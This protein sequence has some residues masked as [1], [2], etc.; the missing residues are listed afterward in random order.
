MPNRDQYADHNAYLVIDL[1]LF[2]QSTKSAWCNMLLVWRMC[3]IEQVFSVD[4]LGALHNL[5]SVVQDCRLV[6]H[7]SILFCDINFLMIHYDIDKNMLHIPVFAFFFFQPCL[8]GN[9]LH[10]TLTGKQ[11]GHWMLQVIRCLTLISVIACVTC[12]MRSLLL[13]WSSRLHVASGFQGMK[14]NV[15][16]KEGI[17]LRE[18]APPSYDMR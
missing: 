3:L 11:G 8:S 18:S 6:K 9:H 13:I 14:V 16:A 15:N 7:L 17:H 10:I 5:L 1:L 12:F 4:L 2:L